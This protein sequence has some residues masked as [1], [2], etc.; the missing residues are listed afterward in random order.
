MMVAK[1]CSIAESAMF[2]H[3]VIPY[4]V[5]QPQVVPIVNG[6]DVLPFETTPYRSANDGDITARKFVKYGNVKIRF[7]VYGKDAPIH[8][9]DFS[10]FM[11]GG[12][13]NMR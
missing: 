6:P 7:G 8:G 5:R 2:D 12:I 13:T 1:T 9:D 4:L 10:D 11:G 3:D